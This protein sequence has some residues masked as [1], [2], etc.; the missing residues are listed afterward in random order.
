[1]GICHINVMNIV[2]VEAEWRVHISGGNHLANQLKDGEVDVMIAVANKHNHKTPELRW[3]PILFF[4][5]SLN[6]SLRS[7]IIKSLF[8]VDL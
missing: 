7:Q 1:M 3:G 6:R 2:N 5:I 8:S 4:S